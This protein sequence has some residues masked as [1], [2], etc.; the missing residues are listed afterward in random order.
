MAKSRRV[1]SCGEQRDRASIAGS[2]LSHARKVPMSPLA[3]SSSTFLP[4]RATA[5]ALVFAFAALPISF[6]RAEQDPITV[7]G[8]SIG[9]D[10]GIDLSFGDTGYTVVNYNDANG[11]DDEG[12]RITPAD[13]GGFWLIGMHAPDQGGQLVAISKLAASGLIDPSF[14]DGGKVAVATDVTLIS[15]GI[16]A[17]NRFYVAGIHVLP[18]GLG[19]FAV[20]CV[21]LDASVCANFGDGGTVI[22]PVN[23][24]GFNSGASRLLFRNGSLYAVGT[25]A[26]DNG[27]GFTAAVAIA[28]LDATTGTL[29]TTFDDGS[30]LVPG[31]VLFDPDLVPNG[32]DYPSALAFAANG[33]VLIGGSAQTGDN[34]ASD[35]FVVALDS[36]S[37]AVDTTFGT[38]GVVYFSFDLGVHFDQVIVTA[39][40]VAQTGRILV[41][42]NANHDDESFNTLTNVLLASL[43]PDGTPTSGFGSNGIVNV[44]VGLNTVTLD[45]AAWADGEILV[46]LS[47]N[48]LIPNDYTPD[49]LESFAEFDANGSGPTSTLSIAFPSNQNVGPTARANSLLVDSQDRILAAGFRLWDFVFPIPDSD[50]AVTRLIHDHVLSSGFDL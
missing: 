30:G 13:D 27:A 32:Y 33:D 46:S 40:R 49:G 20:A 15:D 4:G 48:G 43:E 37:G 19:E 41:A 23:E 6:A 28:K 10:L 17:N 2:P 31:T 25:T 34:N 1:A 12:L 18:S 26:P 29:D 16:F 35:G 21:E 11:T 47:S 22:V 50:H 3:R 8:E 24:T 14:G 44:N 42:G 45:V 9:N 38:D 7:I 39:L 36:S 5:L